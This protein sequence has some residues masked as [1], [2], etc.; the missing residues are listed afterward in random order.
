MD[1]KQDITISLEP[2]ERLVPA[3]GFGTRLVPGP[4]TWIVKSRPSLSRSS[5]LRAGRRRV[6]CG[7]GYFRCGNTLQDHEKE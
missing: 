6:L 4:A 7:Q 2:D 1:T 3:I 5:L